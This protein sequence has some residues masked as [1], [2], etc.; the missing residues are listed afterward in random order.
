M[1][2][3]QNHGLLAT[4]PD[5]PSLGGNIVGGDPCTFHPALWEYLIERFTI[6]TI[7]DVGCGEG[8]CVKFFLD[9]GLK[10]TGFDG[11]ASNVENS[12]VLPVSSRK[13]FVRRLGEM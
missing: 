10:A 5:D 4:D 2:N 11:L 6:E 3:L 8:H 13:T 1:S 7:L 12:V 9:A